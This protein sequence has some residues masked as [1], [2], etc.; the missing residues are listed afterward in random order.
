MNPSMTQGYQRADGRF[1]IRNHLL[2]IPCSVCASEVAIRVAA[3][4]DMAVA[5]PHQHGCC[6]MGEDFRQTVRTLIG[7][8]VHPNVGAVLVIGLG[9]EG[10]QAREIAE[11]IRKSQ[12]PVDLVIIQDEG[13]SIRAQAEGVEKLRKL[14]EKIRDTEK[15]EIP[16]S[17]LIVGLECGGSDP[18]SGIAA[19]PAIGSAAHRV[20]DSGCSAILSETTEEELVRE[21]LDHPIG[22]KKLEEMAKG[23]ENVVILCSDH[24]RP[25]PS[26]ILIPAML[27][28][29][30]K[31]NPDAKI[32]LLIATG[33]HRGTT[34]QELRAKFGDANV[35]SEHIYVHDCDDEELLSH[36]GTLPS[37][38]DIIVNKIAADADLLVAEGFIEPHFFAG[39][40]GGRKSV[41]PGCCSRQTVMYNHNA[42]FIDSANA[43]TGILENNPIHKDMIYA[44]RQLNLVFILNVVI[45]AAKEI[46]HAVA[47]D[48]E[49]A[50]EAG[51]GWLKDLA[52]VP[53]TEAEIVLTS[54]G[55]YPLDQNV[56]QAVKSMTAAEACV[57]KDG[58]I[59]VASESSDGLGGEGFYRSFAEEKDERKMMDEF[60][61]TPKEETI[62]DQWQSQIFARVLLHARVIY[63]SE[64]DDQLIRDLHM[65]PAKDLTEAMRIADEMMGEDARVT[66]IPDGVAVIVNR[67]ASR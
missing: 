13:G 60:L 48:L 64:V 51:T 14:E 58:V 44:A 4:S 9:C 39:Y 59:I 1:G 8:G 22:T 66:V 46:V 15:T 67:A 34:E 29:I 21:A 26:K 61:A 20:V 42:E 40:S 6:Q 65:I 5:I 2:V 7:F 25:V 3:A 55:G 37:G 17:S 19:N 47:G 41:F 45:N 31:G 43:R 30:R 53:R 49:E 52:G 57:V 28:R 11:E 27:E 10:I 56:Y 12:K 63:I 35:D 32:T 24:T 16:V 23:K 62:A 54:N 36:R 38:G 33:C 50:H 18:T